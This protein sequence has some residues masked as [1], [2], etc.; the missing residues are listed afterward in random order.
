LVLVIILVAPIVRWYV[1]ATGAQAE[2]FFFPARIDTLAFGALFALFGERIRRS[3]VRGWMVLFSLAVSACFLLLIPD[4]GRSA[5][6]AVLG[7]TAI[8]FSMALL[9]AFVL[10]RAATSNWLCRYLRCPTLVKLGSISYMFYLVHLF[11]IMTFRRIFA[12]VLMD[13]WAWNRLLQVGGSLAVTILAA[14][15]SWRYFESPILKLKS[16]FEIDHRSHVKAIS[17]DPVFKH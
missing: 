7:Y 4:T 5:F 3:P 10:A 12:N 2:Y 16:H 9:L 6:F 14:A 11:V 13:H 1:H 8:G 17:S 15:L